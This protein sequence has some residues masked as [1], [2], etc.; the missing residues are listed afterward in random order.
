[1]ANTIITIKS[2]GV[3]GNVPSVLQP[4]ELAINYA[5]GDLY[6]GDELNAVNLFDVITEPA[7][8]NRE[9]Q[10]NSS[11]EFGSSNG[12][13]FNSLTEAL[14]VTRLNVDNDVLID[15]DATSNTFI[16]SKLA[17]AEPQPGN[18]TGER[19]RLYD[20]NSISK[21]NY[22]IG[23]ESSAIWN[24]VDT[25]SDNQGF[26][27]YG[28]NVEIARLSATGNLK[29]S[30]VITSDG[31][32]ANTFI[33]FP[34]GTRQFSSS[35]SSSLYANAAFSQANAAFDDSNNRV[36]IFGD[37]MTGDYDI[38]GNIKAT[39]VE[40]Q[41]QLFAGI[42]TSQATLLPNVIAQ[43]T[44]D[45]ESYT[46]VNQQNINANGSADFVATAD[47]GDDEIFYVDLGINNSQFNDPENTVYYPLDGYLITKGSDVGQ[48]GGNLVIGTVT[49]SY[50][51]KIKFVVGG[52]NLENIVA[53]ID[54][55]G[56]Y[57][58]GQFT[59]Q[60]TNT[61][62]SY[63]NSAFAT[64]NLAS[65]QS[66][67]SGVY[68]NAAFEQANT[69]TSNASIADQR[70][71]TSG[72]YANAAFEQANTSDQKAVSAGVYA[73]ASFD[74]ANT[75]NQIAVSAGVYANAAFDV[76]N[77]K[78]NSSGGTIEGDVNVTGNLLISG[79]TTFIDT[80]ELQ[81]GDNI[82]TLNADLPDD[83]P[84][85]E[86]SGIEINRG[87]SSNV[88][89]IWDEFLDK[90]T[91]TN[92][93][94]L[95]SSI[96]SSAAEVYANSAFNQANTSTT[97]AAI[98]D[99]KAVSA[100]VY[101]NAAFDVANTADQRAVT[102]GVYANAAFEQ[103]NSSYDQANTATSNASIADQR[104][105]TSGVYANSAFEQANT[106]TTDA[107]IADQ[108]AVTSGV[109][110]NS[111]FEQANTATTNAAVADQRAVTS[112]VY[113][114]AAF[115]VANTSGQAAV[116]AG[117]YANSAFNQ[118]N[119]ATTDAAVA[120]QRAV[121]SG[122]YANAAFDVANTSQTHSSSAYDQANTATTNAAVADQRA[123]TS[124]VYANAAFEQANTANIVASSS[125]TQSNS[126]YDQANTAT[127]NAAI[128][129]QKAVSAGVY[130]NSAFDQANTAT[131]N[132]AIADQKAVSAGVYANSAFGRANT[133]TNNAATAQIHASSAFDQANTATTNAA[134]ADQKA[135]SAG[136]YANS[137]FNQAN[138]S[139]TNAAIAD[140]KAVSAGVYANA[141]FDVANTSNIVATSSFNQA[142]TA[143]TNASV[144]DQ[145]AVSAGVYANAAFSFANTR[146]SSD[147]GTI[148]GNVTITGNLNVTGNV[149]SYGA[150]EL[151][152]NDPIILL[153]NNNVGNT[154]DIGFTGHY[155]NDDGLT[156]RHLGLVHH[157][158]TET[159]YLFDDYIPHIQENNI[160]D[161]NDASFRVA[162]L[163]ANLITD[164]IF[165][166]GYDPI[167]HA[168][169][170][171]NQ[172]NTATTNAAIADQKAVSAGVYANA[173]F[174]RANT[175]IDSPQAAFDQANTATTNAA[176]ADQK[177]VSAGVYANA[178]FDVANTKVSKSGDTMTGSLTGVTN[179]GVA[180]I[181]LQQSLV[182]TNTFTT[183]SVTE[184]SVDSFSTLSYRSAKYYV[185]MTSGGSYHVIE[186]S[187]LHDGTDVN[188]V[189][190]G[191]IQT[192]SSLG[193]FSST[194][195][196]TTL[197]LLFT[198]TN[199]ITT[200]KLNRITMNV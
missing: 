105:V 24:A 134:I 35:N 98:A 178:A 104:A 111:A 14:T 121:T 118:A 33:E 131:T 82:I 132:A 141:A 76:A 36:S 12:F 101:A 136:V 90:W 2:S 189:Q 182:T 122:V 175:S 157:F 97:N 15:G 80:Q 171:F 146:Y 41:T 173:A 138:T 198:P 62:G 177:A 123:V 107:A 1:M 126:A 137:A 57:V 180:T 66:I 129:D 102:S 23:V 139:T 93:G 79:N 166:R 143:T 125:Y 42:A 73:N 149:I 45:S 59:S 116:S 32:V 165:V 92:D 127:T 87:S 49:S 16:S 46:Q 200:V 163:T 148:D 4:G 88:S 48:E 56:L 50:N 103:A 72:V 20:F 27:W 183:S 113:A 77:T 25:N 99:Q 140:Q 3:T 11:G 124:G 86:D 26:K 6:Y 47:V 94:V 84:P 106:A 52:A 68:A 170:S 142:N 184:V 10:F 30:G 199:S 120:D 69:A 197:N 109:Y 187:L 40:V 38:T 156:I 8:L 74:V 43:F 91:F 75:A 147:G 100:G 160:L 71:V 150:E 169:A 159:F 28:A 176:I 152:I 117:V 153:A 64:S 21:V 81:I 18:Y 144:A 31:F 194:I 13:T 61:I 168:N 9:V 172:A 112:G 158:A 115:D 128:A 58:D 85:T 145:K 164:V 154:L 181:T 186:L 191:E 155:S 135:V 89:L 67:I 108:R 193:T 195:S 5:D 22:S 29:T 185:Q 19:I 78:F 17:L 96:G 83:M 174:E 70:A 162:T 37:N 192:N 39:Y 114:N 133:A 60:T 110:A 34:D 196:G 161:I 167:N 65:Q 188:L 95:Y 179:L 44:S 63:A 119:T 55:S 130:A 7:G 151:K 54:N 190:Y 53:T 51:G